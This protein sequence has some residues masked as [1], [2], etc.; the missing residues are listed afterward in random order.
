[1]NGEPQTLAEWLRAA[2]AD[3]AA[4]CPPPES[5]LVDELAALTPAD[6]ERLEAHAA[7]C[8]ACSAERELAQAFDAGAA[9]AAAGDVAW[10]TA[11]LTVPG[12]AAGAPTAAPDAAA[13]GTAPATPPD[14]A[15]GATGSPSPGQVLAFPGRRRAMRWVRLAAAAVLVVAAGLVFQTLHLSTPPLPQ[16]PGRGTVRGGTVAAAAPAGELADVPSALRW[17]ALPGAAAYRVRLY[18]VDDTE[19]WRGVAAEPGVDLP[20]EVMA[21]IERAVSYRWSVEAL[22]A[23][24]SVLGRSEP[25][26]FRVAPEPEAPAEDGR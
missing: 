18:T 11:R 10:V 24:G 22:A 1:V 2:W 15:P 17:E 26:R 8:P 5:W 25:T 6:R 13:G 19:V 7:G 20:A 21:G 23:D 4:G 3:E 9:A 14:E 16:P 12:S